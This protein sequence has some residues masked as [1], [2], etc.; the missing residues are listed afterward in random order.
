MSGARLTFYDP[1]LKYTT[2]CFQG[3]HKKCHGNYGRCDCECHRRSMN[4]YK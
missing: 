1:D 4:D 2:N 3:R